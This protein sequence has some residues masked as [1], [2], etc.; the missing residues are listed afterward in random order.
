MWALFDIGYKSDVS[1]AVLSYASFFHYAVG[2]AHLVYSWCSSSFT[3]T[4]YAFP[5]C[6]SSSPVHY[7]YHLALQST[8]VCAY[9]AL[10][11]VV[12]SSEGGEKGRQGS[13]ESSQNPL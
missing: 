4:S 8:R 12:G 10:L 3:V 11:I 9:L 1:L 6:S 5:S 2:S 13:K 7:L